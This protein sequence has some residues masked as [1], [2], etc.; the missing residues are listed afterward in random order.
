MTWL[1][2]ETP[3]GF[4]QVRTRT[5]TLSVPPDQPYSQPFWLAQP[6]SGSAYTIDPQE[7]RDKPDSP[8]YYVAT[9]EIQAGSERLELQRPLQN[10]YIDTARGELTRPV[11]IVPAVAVNLSDS[12]FVFPNGKPLEVQAHVRANVAGAAGE[13]RLQLGNGWKAEP[14]SRS[15]HLSEIGEQAD[16]S[17]EVT[18]G[19]AA[20]ANLQ[21][22]ASTGGPRPISS[23]MR[24]MSYPHI[25]VEVTFPPAEARLERFPVINLAKK[26]GY[27]MGPGD[28]VP[29]ALR[30]L[31]SEVV[32]LGP[33]DLASRN[34]SE[35][36]AI[37]T[38][39]RAYN[40]RSDLRANEGRLL[41]YV[42][43]GGTLIVQ[44][45]YTQRPSDAQFLSQSRIGPYPMKFTT[46]RT[47]ME[48][49]PVSFPDPNHPLLFTPNK[50]TEHDFDGWVQER[51]LYYASEFDP[52]YQP[53][54]ESHDPGDK[55]QL[56]GTLYTRYGK[57][58][59]IFTAYSWFRQ[60][61][62][63]VPGAYRI[64]ANFLSAGKALR[65]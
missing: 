65:R 50:I 34:L 46:A 31:G 12:A 19:T 7:M 44:Y 25:P 56:G 64:F 4:N 43:D 24:V 54:F 21:A 13:L 3:L 37:V 33:G 52:H 51:G 49:A 42:Q 58:V 14:A 23:G 63:G 15:F 32:L 35:F 20:R 40:E 39:V 6:K 28:D 57:G 17:F 10:R 27:I 53:V 2:P 29:Q 47:T 55:P 9:F 8:P 16:L 36:D 22:I 41:N 30:Q 18:P 45:N 62:A 26:V 59:Y 1:G 38:G 61:P 11:A 5:L 60:L 48:E